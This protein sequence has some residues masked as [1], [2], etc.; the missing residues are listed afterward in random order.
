VESLI[1]GIIGALIG[2]CITY[3]FSFSLINFKEFSSIS[4]KFK[5]TL[6]TLIHDLKVRTSETP[7]NTNDVI[8]EQFNELEKTLYGFRLFLPDKLSKELYS[9][10]YKVFYI[11]SSFDQNNVSSA[12]VYV[13]IYKID[14]LNTSELIK[15]KSNKIIKQSEYLIEKY[16]NHNFAF[17][18]RINKL[19]NITRKIIK[20]IVSRCS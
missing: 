7:K 16:T 1:S 10:W 2:S 8:K 11:Q 9:D 20:P 13:P 15:Y 12:F 6:I 4:K 17:Y 5:T 14:T 19:C 18:L 3:I